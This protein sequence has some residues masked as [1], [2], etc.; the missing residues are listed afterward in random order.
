MY[1]NVHENWSES[2]SLIC[3]RNGRLVS[4][5][6]CY[7]TTFDPIQFYHVLI[8]RF[9]H[10][11]ESVHALVVDLF[12]PRRLDDDNDDNNNNNNEQKVE[13]SVRYDSEDNEE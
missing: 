7:V 8:D 10:V 2:V 13:R 3:Y 4:Y 12:V 9:L 11:D 1:L 5:V 6:L